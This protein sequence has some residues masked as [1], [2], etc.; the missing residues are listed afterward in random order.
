[1][2]RTTFWGRDENDE[3]LVEQIIEGKKTA[4]CTPKCW[5]DALPEEATEVG[6]MLE[7]FSKKGNYMCTIE[8]TKK[9]EVPFGQ[10]DDETVR[11]ENCVSYEEFRKDHIFAWE[12]DLKRE[13]KELNDHTIIVVEHFRLVQ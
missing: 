4:T 6:E 13:G 7:V 12:N 1:M 11:G 3:R 10:I 5:Y 9:Y 8:I 2:K